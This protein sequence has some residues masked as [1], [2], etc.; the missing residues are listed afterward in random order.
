MDDELF[1]LVAPLNWNKK[2]FTK[3]ILKF[4]LFMVK[5]LTRCCRDALLWS[6]ITAINTRTLQHLNYWTRFRGYHEVETV[7]THMISIFEYWFVFSTYSVGF[8]L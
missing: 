8:C 5:M 3:S 7:G 6:R 1:I 2:D 4:S